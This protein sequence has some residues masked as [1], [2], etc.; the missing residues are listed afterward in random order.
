MKLRV[1]FF[2]SV[3][4][5][6][7]IVGTG[8]QTHKA[9]MPMGGGYEEVS[10]PHHTLIDE[11]EPPR[12]SF[13]HRSPDG[14][15]TQIWPSLYTVN[16]VIKGDLAIFI[17]DKAYVVPAPE[18]HPRLFAV[19][20]PDLPLDLTD[21]VLWRWSK[22]N[23]KD[24]TRTLDKFASI[25]ADESNGQLLLRIEFWPKS[26]LGSVRE[27]WPDQSSISFD[28]HQVDEMMRAVK[29]KGVVQKDLRWHTEYIGEKF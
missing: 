3:A 12:I 28:W 24:F 1:C 25:T 11:P 18:T 15:I 26:D 19:R 5:L 23:G 7:A 6:S 14:E 10:H 2:S 21:E 22:A 17:A 16:D 27:D 4:A 8:C 29:A 13:Q 20:S 9:V